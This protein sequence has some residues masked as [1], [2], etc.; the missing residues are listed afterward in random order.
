V[1][2]DRL[3]ASGMVALVVG[4]ELRRS[5]L[6][7]A[8]DERRSCE[9]ELR[10]VDDE[11]GGDLTL[12]RASDGAPRGT[13]EKVLSEWT[14]IKLRRRDSGRGVDDVGEAG[15]S[16]ACSWWWWRSWSYRRCEG[17]AVGVL[18]K[19]LLLPLP[20]AVVLVLVLVMLL[21]TTVELRAGVDGGELYK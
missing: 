2:G 10:T 9:L 8:E 20:A 21:G 4:G 6:R 5:S 14:A 17:A 11:S 15:S 1:N 13:R 18:R 7:A 16:A 19:L 12:P 3:R